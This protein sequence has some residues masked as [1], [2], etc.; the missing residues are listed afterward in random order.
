MS[1][2]PVQVTIDSLVR[3][4]LEQTIELGEDRIHAL[5]EV[6]HQLK[7]RAAKLRAKRFGLREGDVKL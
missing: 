6:S 3:H 2:T 1:N 7:E 5:D 4:I